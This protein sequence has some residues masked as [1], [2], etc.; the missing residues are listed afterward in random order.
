M[1]AGIPLVVARGMV[2]GA[3]QLEAASGV[4]LDDVEFVNTL[5]NQLAIALD[6]DRTRRHDVVRPSYR[7]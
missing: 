6:R 2:F 3:L 1:R 4:D 5:A 7:K